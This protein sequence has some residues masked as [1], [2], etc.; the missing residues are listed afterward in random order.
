MDAHRPRTM[1]ESRNREAEMRGGVAGGDEV[2]KV[3][4]VLLQ[5]RA[6]IGE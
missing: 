2:L 5:F 4:E 1:P 3:D 6:V